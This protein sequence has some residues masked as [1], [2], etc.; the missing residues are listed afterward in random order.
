MVSPENSKPE[1]FQMADADAFES[2]PTSKKVMRIMA[3]ATP[4]L[5]LG[6][7]LV[8]AQGQDSPSAVASSA[9]ALPLHSTGASSPTSVQ[10]SQAAS[11]TQKAAITIKKPGISTMPTGG[12]ED[13]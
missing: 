7:E 10:I 3:L 5:I 11:T 8:V 4:L 12:G 1:W 2:K 13:D 9:T 6:A